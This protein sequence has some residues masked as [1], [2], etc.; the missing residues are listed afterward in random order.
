MVNDD[1]RRAADKLFDPGGRLTC[2]DCREELID[3]MMRHREAA[4]QRGAEAE[5]ARIERA[6]RL[7][8]EWCANWGMDHSMKVATHAA[9]ECAN[10]LATLPAELPE[11]DEEAAAAIFKTL[12]WWIEA[13]AR[14]NAKRGDHMGDA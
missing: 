1:D 3:Q 4:E 10:M 9:N 6:L 2:F 11:D 8:P 13:N 12:P 7:Y 14:A 5:R